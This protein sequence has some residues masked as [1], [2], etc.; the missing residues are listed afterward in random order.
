M[1]FK[2][3][4][5][6]TCSLNCKTFTILILAAPLK[7]EMQCYMLGDRICQCNLMNMFKSDKIHSNIF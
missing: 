1:T 4:Y 2:Y 5:G 3:I 7:V 6:T